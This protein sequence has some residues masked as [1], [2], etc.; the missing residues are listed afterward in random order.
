MY[1]QHPRVHLLLRSLAG[2]ACFSLLSALP[3][4]ADVFGRLHVTVKD[5]AT[6]K[7]I[8]GAKITLHDTANVRADVPLTVDST[9]L[10]TTPPLEIRPWQVTTQADLYE[11]DTRQVRVAADTTTEV[12]VLLEPKKE[13]VITI[14]GSRTMVSQGQTSDVTQRSETFLKDMPATAGNPMSLPDIMLTTPGAAQDSVNQVHFRGEHSSTTIYIDGYQ[15]PGA[16]QGRAGQILVPDTIQSAQILTGGYAPEYGSETAAIMNLNLRAGTIKPF[17]DYEFEGGGY[18][19]ANAMITF[20][21]QAGAPIGAPQANGARARNFGYLVSL[22]SQTTGLALEPPQPGSNEAA[23]NGG[24]MADVFGNFSYSMGPQD[25]LGLTVNTA[26]A[27]TEIAN[28]TGLSSEF[29]SVGQGYGF[30]GARN[31]DGT[32]PSGIA[33]TLGSGTEVLPSQQDAGQDVYQVDSNS[34]AKLNYRHTFSDALTTLVTVGTSHSGME[35]G[36]HN[37]TINNL[38]ALPV[39][40]SIEYNPQITKNA[41]DTQVAASATLAR[42]RHTF[43]AGGLYDGQSG[44]ESYQ[45]TPGSLLALDALAVNDPALAPAGTASTTQKDVLG[46]PVYTLNSGNETAPILQVHRSGYY[47]AGYV[48]DTWSATKKLTAAY[49]LRLDSYG[50]SENLGLASVNDTELSPRINLAYALTP[51]TIGR[52]SYNHLFTQ[53]PLAQGDI[54]GQPIHPE[55]LNQYDV[56][57]ERQ[58]AAGQTAKIAYYYKQINNQIDTGLLVPYTQ[59]GAYT[60]V[61]FTHGGVHGMELS[62]DESPRGGVGLSGF[63]NYTYSI[64]QPNGLTDGDTALPLAPLYNDHDQRHT[65]SS[66][67]SYSLK[68]GAQAA[69]ELNYGS[70]VTSSIIGSIVPTNTATVNN[71]ERNAHTIVNLRFLSPRLTNTG[72][73]QLGVDVENLFDCEAV[74]NFNS[75]FSGTRFVQGRRIVARMKGTF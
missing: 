23:H 15:L 10:V 53:P 29:S 73:L 14:K 21:G 66:G 19:T 46:N 5:A 44:S 38:G 75:G 63:A 50:Q 57:V 49:G 27:S 9:G 45:L 24:K 58:V 60:S 30:G 28:R 16:L 41:T 39:D 40:N 62:Y 20:G 65:V 47:A 2:A 55:T 67:V 56:S 52:L 72:K 4:N 71:D 59:F 43:K 69:A 33:G 54:I 51:L 74:M 22:N 11:S 70:G 13:E 3:A 37:P 68:S 8:A 48:Q 35:I 32:I 31:P 64:A 26:P 1:R 7:P 12:E 42:S 18:S 25:E 34:F 36:N 17:L 6:E 61:N